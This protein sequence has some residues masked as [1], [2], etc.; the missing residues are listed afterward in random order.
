MKFPESWL[1]SFV[2]PPLAA[3]ALADALAMGGIDV[4]HVEPE[5]DAGSSP[6]SPHPTAA[7]A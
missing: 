1:R 3:R 6:P 4:E 7:I 5:R 2:N